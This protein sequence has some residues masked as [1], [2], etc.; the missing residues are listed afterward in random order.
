[1][2]KETGLAPILEA[3]GLVKRYGKTQALAGLDLVVH[4]GRVVALLEPNGS[5]CG[6]RSGTWS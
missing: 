3:R 6:T 1:V 2:T 4:P 5:S